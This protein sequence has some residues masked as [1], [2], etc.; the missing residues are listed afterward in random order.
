MPTVGIEPTI[1][2]LR[3]ERLTTWPSGHV[4]ESLMLLVR[5]EA[6][7]RVFQYRG[8]QMSPRA[9]YVSINVFAV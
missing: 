7:S 4:F 9:P 1:A 5:Y 8:G 2:P 6:R 3:V